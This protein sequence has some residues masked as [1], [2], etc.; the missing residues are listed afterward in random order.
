MKAM[1]MKVSNDHYRRSAGFTLIEVTLAIAITAIALVGLMG[2]LPQ[3][4]K[5]LAAAGERAVEARI[6]QGVMSELQLASWERSG[7][8]NQVPID[9]LN[10]DIRYYDDQGIDLGAGDRDKTAFTARINILKRGESLPP[11]VGGG[12]CSG[13][14][15]PGD[16]AESKNLRLVIVEIAPISDDSF[17]FDDANMSRSVKTFRSLITKMG[18]DYSE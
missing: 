10:G 2:L 14:N 18:Q 16:N 8:T 11:S 12:I 1:N 3:G 5:T 7:R 13:V 4:M 9:L 6:H 17:N 15:L